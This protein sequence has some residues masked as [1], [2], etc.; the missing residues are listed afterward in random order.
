MGLSRPAWNLR[1][2]PSA[3]GAI[4]VG[5]VFLGEAA[6]PAKLLAAGLILSGL[7]LMKVTTP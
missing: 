3:V 4:A 1:Q 7:V 5:I 6:S 2:N